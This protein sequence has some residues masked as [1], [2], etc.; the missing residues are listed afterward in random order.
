MNQ[1]VTIRDVAVAAGFSVNTVSRALNEK[2]DVSEKTR[3]AILEA[4]KKMGYRPNRLA[5]GLR[6]NKTQTIGVIVADIA[7][8]F[9][10][11]VVKG[12]EQAASKQGL[13]IIL[14]NSDETCKREAKAIQVMLSE[15][16]D[17]ILITPCQKERKTI[18]DL[19]QSGLPFVLLGRCFDDLSIDYVIPN[20]MYGGFLATKHLLEIG[21]TRIAIVNAPLYISSAKHRLKGYKKALSQY[22]V[23]VDESL[24]TS[25]ALTVKEG[26]RVARSILRQAHRPT[27]IFAYSDFVAF[28]VMKAIREAGLRV[29]EDI[30]VVG[31]DD[32]EFSS[33]LEVSLTT[34][35]SPKERMGREGLKILVA[36]LK[37]GHQ[38]SKKAVKLKLGVELA[39]RQ[40]SAGKEVSAPN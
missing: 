28:G 22:G 33:C 8:P 7:N 24:I 20:D 13:S 3:R 11:A 36:K 26:Y 6:S 1:H 12:I 39:V 15:K 21:H 25:Q 9:F 23:K 16:V 17:G 19:K 10:G 27:A 37:D 18:I 30:A 40:S 14:A 29:P 4:A 31:F 2:P 5:R 34:V 38:K 32:V 35:V